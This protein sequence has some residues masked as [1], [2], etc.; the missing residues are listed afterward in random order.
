[1]VRNIFFSIFILIN[2]ITLA[3]EE[4]NLKRIFPEAERSLRI[5]QPFP[6]TAFFRKGRELVGVCFVASEVIS[7]TKGFSGEIKTLICI[8]KEAKVRTV[9]VI[10]HNETPGWGDKIES[11]EFLSQFKGKYIY[12]NFLVGEDIQGISGATISSKS[13][14]RIV[15][16]ASHRAYEEIFEKKSLSSITISFLNKDILLVALFLFLASL[17]ILGRSLFLRGF[18]LLLVIIYFGF[19]K[20]LFISIFNVVQILRIQFPSFGDSLFWY[21]LFVFSFLGTVFLGRFYCGWL[22][23]FGGIQEFLSKIPLKKLKVPYHL[24]SYLLKVKYILLILALFLL[25]RERDF[26]FKI[27][28]FSYFFKPSLFSIFFYYSLVI[29]VISIFI[30]R[31]FCRYLCLVG[32]I[33]ALLSKV[34]LV[35]YRLRCKDKNCKVCIKRCPLGIIDER[36]KIQDEECIRCNICQDCIFDKKK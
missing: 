34:S 4:P 29:L 26:L 28:P 1:M 31:F 2:T 33:F 20:G 24:N 8:D 5:S 13:L 21:I 10:S 11:K 6:Y 9:E 15:K 17:F 22:C 3:Q 19:L 35:K 18:F 30:P 32:A 16:E 7:N 23:P 27:E 14:A 25:L 12:D 36:G